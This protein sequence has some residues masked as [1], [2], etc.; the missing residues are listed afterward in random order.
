[1]TFRSGK[2]TLDPYPC[3]ANGSPSVALF[4]TVYD[5]PSVRKSNSG[6]ISCSRRGPSVAQFL[7]TMTFGPERRPWTPSF[8]GTGTISRPISNGTMTLRSG[9][10]TMDPYPCFG[11][12]PSSHYSTYDT[13]GPEKQLWTLS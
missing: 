7:G 6:H 11:T 9:K 4:L 3:F 2:A 5:N 10:A 8:L 12:G 1:M 13:F